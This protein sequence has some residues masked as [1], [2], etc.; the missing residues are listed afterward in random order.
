MTVSPATGQ[1]LDCSIL[2]SEPAMAVFTHHCYEYRRGLRKLIMHT[3]PVGHEGMIRA[4]LERAG[5]AYHIQHVGDG[6]RILNVFF[7]CEAHVAVVRSF[8]DK[9]VN[10]HSPE[11]D[12]ILGTLLGYDGTEQCQRYLFRI[13]QRARRN[14]EA[15]CDCGRGA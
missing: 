7:G 2:R 14:A 5:F 13:D 1:R 15:R 3:A 4:H 12:F 9:P 8:G 11:Q 6:D 10:E